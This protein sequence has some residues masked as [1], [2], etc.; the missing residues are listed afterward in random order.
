MYV[1]VSWK[2]KYLL[3]AQKQDNISAPIQ[4]KIPSV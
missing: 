3:L 4:Q 1:E 2:G